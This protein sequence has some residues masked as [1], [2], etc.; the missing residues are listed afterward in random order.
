[1]FLARTLGAGLAA[2]LMAGQAYALSLGNL[3]IQS[4][5]NEPLRAQISIQA[6]VSELD[7]LKDLSVALS[8]SET[9]KRLGI[10]SS[11][12]QAQLRVAL[13]RGSKQEPVAIQ[14]SSDEVLKLSSDEVFLDA[15]VEMRWPAGMLRRA[16]T[17]MV[18]D[19]SK[20][21]VKAGD[22][23]T[24]L[25]SKV[26][27]NF[28]DV[29]LDQ[30][31][32]ALYRANPQAFAGGSIHRL[33]VGAELKMPSKSMVQS[34]PKHEAREIVGVADTAYRLGKS[35]EPLSQAINIKSELMGDRLRVSPAEGLNGEAKR[36]MEDLL[37]QERALAEAKQRVIEV[38]KNIADLKRLIESKEKGS[39]VSSNDWKGYAGPIMI[40]VFILIALLILL[41]LSRSESKKSIR[42]AEIPEHAAKLFASLNLDL[43]SNP[44]PS[45]NNSLA[46]LPSAEN[47]KVKLNLARA[48]I[49]IE[50]FGAA[51]KTLDEVLLVSSFVDPDL[52]IQAKSLLAEIDQRTS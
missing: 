14:L 15:L 3:T 43:S 16:Y 26:L 28:E 7:A 47:L 20:V 23:L 41:K 29:S 36:Q 50:D 22:T 9:Y 27:P 40:T 8:N 6:E 51:R 35:A 18:G 19:Q 33:M 34:I 39:A 21:Q 25:A 11:A 42:Q 32:I 1:L 17:L 49:T 37:V 46:H 2:L 12:T 13:I 5:A 24:D 44:S 31:L 48:Y 10:V 45:L 4:K 30:A 38:E 52:T